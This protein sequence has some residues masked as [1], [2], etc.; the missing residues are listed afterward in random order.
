[1]AS[2]NRYTTERLFEPIRRVARRR[3]RPGGPRHEGRGILTPNS[4]VT[5]AGYLQQWLE[6]VVPR[7]NRRN[8]ARG[9]EGVVRLHILPR[10]GSKRLTQLTVRDVQNAA[11]ALLDEGH[12]IRTAQKFRTVLSAALTRAMRDEL[13]SRNV[14]RLI[15]LFTNEGVVG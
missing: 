6:T 3:K 13:V 9:Y 8:T 10:I 4:Q 2:R 11:C 1:M 14:A 5:V 15:G 7:R 12:S